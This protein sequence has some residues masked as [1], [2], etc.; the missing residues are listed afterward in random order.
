MWVL[1]LNNKY[2]DEF[3]LIKEYTATIALPEVKL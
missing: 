1:M 2:F 3:N